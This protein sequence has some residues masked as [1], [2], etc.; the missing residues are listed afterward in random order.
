MTASGDC[1]L[2]DCSGLAMLSSNNPTVTIGGD[3]N[4]SAAY[5]YIG[6]GIHHNFRGNSAQSILGSVCKGPT[7][8][9]IA[10][11]GYDYGYRVGLNY[12]K[13]RSWASV[14]GDN[15]FYDDGEG[16]SDDSVNHVMRESF[17]VENVIDGTGNSH[18]QGMYDYYTALL[19]DQ[20]GDMAHLREEYISM[21]GNMTSMYDAYIMSHMIDIAALTGVTSLLRNYGF[22]QTRAKGDCVNIN[23]NYKFIPAYPPEYNA[24]QYGKSGS[25][26]FSKGVYYHPEPG[27]LGLGFVFTLILINFAVMT[28]Y[29]S[30]Q[31]SVP[32][33]S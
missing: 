5:T 1:I 13:F 29:R 9:L 30:V 3:Y 20:S 27:D 4:P 6:K 2:I 22:L 25:S 12:A 15:S 32:G 24:Q 28:L 19:T 33:F 21:Y 16:G 14:N 31:Q 8:T 11:D 26:G 17:F 23:Y 7:T 10:N 18:V